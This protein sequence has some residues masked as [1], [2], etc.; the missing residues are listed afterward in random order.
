MNVTTIPNERT[1]LKVVFVHYS[2]PYPPM[3]YDKQKAAINDI[4]CPKCNMH[5]DHVLKAR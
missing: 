5:K 4:V 2:K 3:I 1:I